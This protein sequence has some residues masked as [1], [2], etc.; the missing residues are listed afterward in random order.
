MIYPEFKYRFNKVCGFIF[1][2]VLFSS[3]KKEG[4]TDCNASNYS[5]NAEVD[6]RSCVYDNE[7]RAALYA[8]SDSI[9]DPFQ[10]TFTNTYA[11]D[12]QY[13]ECD[14]D[15]MII[16]NYG[17]IKNSEGEPIAAAITLLGDSIFIANQIIEGPDENA[18]T[19]FIEIFES[20]VYFSNDSVYID[21]SYTDR[22]D[23]YFGRC[24]GEKN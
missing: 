21:L 2:A 12:L 19:D 18:T 11:I 23:P 17:D 16:N 7:E 5:A 4:C 6:D 15:G 8:V 10:S 9:T 1:I 20:K 24:W 22:F 13:G 14:P 3:C